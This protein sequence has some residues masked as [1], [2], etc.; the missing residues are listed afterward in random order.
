[1][2]GVRDLFAA[3]RA[4][5]VVLE[6]PATGVELNR[7]EGALGAR[8]PADVREFY[9]E[10]NGMADLAYDQHE[11]SFWSIAKILNESGRSEG[12]DPNGPYVDHAVG[13]FLINSW[14]ICFRVRNGKVTVFLEGTGEEFPNLSSFAARYVNA[15][16]SL[17]AFNSARRLTSGCS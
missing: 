2:Q 7:L 15:P 12:S 5:G 16:E 6:P 1:M 13:D 10:A 17:A 14:F 9:Q 4:Q 8:L 3:W 11:I